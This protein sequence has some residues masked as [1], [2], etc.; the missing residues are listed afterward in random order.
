MVGHKIIII[1]IKSLKKR[2]PFEFKMVTS[3]TENQLEQIW[4]V[5]SKEQIYLPFVDCTLEATKQNE[6]L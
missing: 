2:P 1:I 5:S 3:V 4:T 6:K